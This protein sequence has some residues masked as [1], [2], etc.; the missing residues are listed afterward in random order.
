MIH[1]RIQIFSSGVC[2]WGGVRPGPSGIKKLWQR[3]LFILFVSHQLILQKSSGYFQR[4]LSFS[5]VPMGWN[6]FQG[7]PTFSRG[8][9][10]LFTYRNLY[11]LWFSKGV[12]TP[13]PH[14]LDPPMWFRISWLNLS[15]RFSLF[16]FNIT[17][18]NSFVET[19]GN[20]AS[21]AVLS[22]VVVIK[23]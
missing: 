19:G 17:I 4:K 13:C 1:A 23:Y 2:V 12:Q 5:K 15:T 11:S 9:Q 22:V 10:L 16:F 3:F 18:A 21:A 20:V 14:P 7:G 8:V 6:I